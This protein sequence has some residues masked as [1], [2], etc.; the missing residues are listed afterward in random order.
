MPLP[1]QALIAPD[2]GMARVARIGRVR[3]VFLAAAICSLAL[4][5]AQAARVD[6]RESQLRQLDQQGRLQQMSDRQID[7]AQKSAERVF[8][9]KKLAW[10]AVEPGGELLFSALGLFVLSWFLRGRSKGSELLAVS[11]YALLP[12]AV[13]NAVDAAAVVA[14]GSLSPDAPLAVP[15][16]LASVADAFGHHL[17]PMSAAFKLL[18]VVDVFALWGA[19]MMAFGLATAAQIPTR[20][21]ILGTIALW[22]GYRLVRTFALGA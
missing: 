13:A 16:T 4:G 3:W 6:A 5:A 9:V 2:Q 1:L 22:V 12:S 8:M 15:R 19:V 11:G 7:D 17:E 20:R 14:R 18:S 21:A 10:G